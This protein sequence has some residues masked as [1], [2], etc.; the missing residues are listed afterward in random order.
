[1]MKNQLTRRMRNFVGDAHR[2]AIVLVLL[3]FLAVIHTSSQTSVAAGDESVVWS[4]GHADGSSIEFAPGQRDKTTFTIGRSTPEKD[5]P[6]RQSGSISLDASVPSGGKPY[7]V[8]FDFEKEAKQNYELVV[9][10]IFQ[11]AA[12]GEIKV[13]VNDRKGIFP[14]LPQPKENIDSDEGNTML[15]AKQRL[16]VPIEASW[17]KIKDNRITLVPLG[18]GEVSYDALSL[19]K[20]GV[21]RVSSTVG[22]RLEPTIFFRKAKEGLNEVCR[23][24]V[25]FSRRFARGSATVTVGQQRV[26]T[27]ISDP[28]YD[29]GVLTN[30]VEV[31]V[32]AQPGKATVKVTL[33]GRTQAATQ[34]CTPARQWKLYVCPKVHNDLGY[35]D[36]QPQID[37]L[38]TRNTDIV[39]D[40]FAKYPFYKFNFET[41]WLAENYLD[42]RPAE[43]R[44]RFLDQLRQGRSA[45]NAFYFHLLT[46]LCSGEEL[47]RSLYFAY[48][49]H[50][51]HGS[52]FDS[53]CLSDVPSSTWFLPSLLTDVGIRAFSN[54]SN[55]TRAPVLHST[56][57]NE[58]SPFYWE[59][60]NG[61]RLLMWYSRSY[62]QLKLLVSP[63]SRAP[64]SSYEYMRAAVPQFL[65]R[66]MRTDYPSDAV[67]IYGAYTDNAVIPAKGEGDLIER[68]NQEYEFPKLI[69]ATDA[70]YFAHVEK[71]FADH[72]PVHRGDAGA[73][74][75]DGA[76][77]TSH[78]T[79]LNQQAK[80]ILPEAETIA[81]FAAL[82]D[83]R[84]LYPAEKFRAGWKNV[85]FYDEHTWG[86]HT[87]IDQPDRQFVTRQWEIKESY[88]IRANLD[89]RNLL[90]RSLYR[91]FQEMAVD[92]DTIFAVNLQPWART[93][94]LEVEIDE[95]RQLV[96]LSDNKPVKMDTVFEGD[97]WRKVRF[98]ADN[99]P[100]MGYKGYA[101]R[102]LDSPRDPA[103][104]EQVGPRATI[105]NQYYRLEVDMRTGG[106]KSL[107]DKTAGKELVDRGASY[108]LNQ[109][110]YVSG[111]ADTLIIDNIYGRPSADL[112]IDSPTSARIVE[113]VRTPLGQRLVVE[114]HAKNTPKIRSEYRL[115]EGLRR[116][117][118]LNTLHKQEVRDQEAAYFAFPFATQKPGLEYQ[119]QNGWVRPNDDQLPGA[120]REWFT[121]QNLVHVKDDLFSIAWATPDAPLMTLTDINRGKW[122]KH[123]EIKNG[124]VFSYVMNNYWMT[125]YKAAQGGDFS[126]RYYITSGK[127]LTREGLSRFDA[128]TRTPVF[129]YPLLSTPTV[130]VT[131]Q[132]KPLNPTQGSLMMVQAP[133]LE[134]VTF[135]LAEDG[136]GYILRLKEVAGRSGETEVSFPLLRIAEA[137]LCNGVEAVQHK[138]PATQ[139]SVK[140]P[141]NANRYITVRLKAAG[142]VRR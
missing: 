116:V 134:F 105:E 59:G 77:S 2:T 35:T 87:S 119:I 4:I 22:L 6:A 138:L 104:A 50:K 60:L 94:P 7:T 26:T 31:P 133:N 68:W 30:T 84:N 76:G 140:V 101:L 49:L 52:N 48:R 9:D 135:K 44:D 78:A 37:E 62:L 136:D 80:Q 81:S 97:G 123:L 32:A 24:F 117:E 38:D 66:Y 130:Q 25:P 92:S 102:R 113:S 93:G 88:A 69:V 120:C 131:G 41:A 53:A 47:Y 19:R 27:R 118:I 10:F 86:A 42:S 91:L 34:D 137:Y 112:K 13:E 128:E 141:Y 74:W 57:L 3:A 1:M 28:G 110:L 39:L 18:V 67:M 21:D 142:A 106:L 75:E 108:T 96:D 70:E 124:H 89:A 17:L 16:V 95:G 109:F 54:A 55:Q 98:M 45:L 46:G 11:V 127:G 51:E 40:L 29:F 33:D 64:V 63:G 58:D 83:P 36:L 15:L 126:F 43:F 114:T 23:L 107:F 122:L 79:K 121:T 82:F 5:F 115:Y 132:G 99:V 103:Q 73:Y 8:V 12:P 100:A 71:H 20:G 129:A 90:S 85:L 125:N 139:T 14:L 56:R 61:E 111:G 65:L 72:L